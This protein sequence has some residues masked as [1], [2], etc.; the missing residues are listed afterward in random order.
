MEA[1][2]RFSKFVPE[3]LIEAREV[4]GYTLT[5]LAELLDVSH[6]AISKYEKGKA[7]PS[8]EILEKIS[9]ILSVPVNY[10]YKPMEAP[11]DSVIYFRSKSNSTVR[12]KKVHANKLN[13]VKE[14]HKYTEQFIEYPSLNI[15]R[16]IT[17]ENYFPTDFS[18]IDEMAIEVRKQ[19][20]LGNGPI[21]NVTLLLEKMGAIIARASFSNYSIDACS[22]WHN[23][24]RPYI[25]LSSDKTASRSRF[26]I[27]HELAHL[28]LHSKIKPNEF[29]KREN[30]S[31][32]EKEAHRFAGSFLLPSP[33][34][35]SEIVSSSIEH[36]IALKKRWKVSIAAM[37]YRAKSLGILTDDQYIYMR[38]KMAKNNWLTKEPLD[39]ELTF[40]D[41]VLLKQAFEALVEN[42]IIIRQD[43]VTEIALPREEIEAFANL[44]NG[45]LIQN[46][47]AKVIPF[48][49]K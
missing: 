15:P 7:T 37:S 5:D 38:K 44:D 35:C 13:R 11:S 10:F 45:Y 39:D 14:I 36:F 40:E 21:S 28:V 12:S 42:K 25:L 4:T 32:I 18:L 31:R 29:N 48:K 17:R 43:I 6:Q 24:E 16:L 27:A 49:F 20:G 30:Y 23:M 1:N 8:F 41:P 33:S 46:E 22:S 47:S 26:D 19:W 34:F 2:S 3:R 9:S